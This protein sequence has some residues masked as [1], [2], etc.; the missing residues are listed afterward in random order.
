M[1]TQKETLPQIYIKHIHTV[2]PGKII[3]ADEYTL[4]PVKDEYF[5]TY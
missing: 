2:K 1:N 5:F 3:A 4:L